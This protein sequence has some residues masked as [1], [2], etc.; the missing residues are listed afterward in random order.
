MFLAK[1]EVIVELDRYQSYTVHTAVIV[2]LLP[3][4][5][6]H[7]VICLNV[8]CNSDSAEKKTNGR[9]LKSHF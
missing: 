9:T 4:T 3:F 5:V 8:I 6:L 2:H 7:P 1:F